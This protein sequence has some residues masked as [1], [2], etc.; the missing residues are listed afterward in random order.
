MPEKREEIDIVE[1]SEPEREEKRRRRKLQKAEKQTLA[2]PVVRENHINAPE[3]DSLAG[4]VRNSESLGLLLFFNSR[5]IFLI[6]SRSAMGQRRNPT[7]RKDRR[8]R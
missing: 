4:S 5:L 1:D 2:K 8:G 6:I 3:I 7:S